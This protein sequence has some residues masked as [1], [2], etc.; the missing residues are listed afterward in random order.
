MA[1]TTTKHLPHLDG[2][3]GLAILFLLAGHFFPVRGINLGGLGVNFFF[4]LSGL[5]M[6]RILF[7][8]GVSIPTFYRRRI[9]RIFPLVYFFLSTI[10][11]WYL[12]RGMPVAWSEVLAAASFLN[13]YIR[14]GSSNSPMPFGHIWSLCV[15]EHAYVVLALVA[16]GVRAGWFRAQAAIGAALLGMIALGLAYSLSYHGPDLYHERWLRSEVSG[17]G[18]FVSVFLLLAFHGRGPRAVSWA[19]I[20]ALVAFGLVMHWWWFAPPARTFLGVTALAA[21]VNLLERAPG[22]VRALLSLRALRQ[23]GIWSFS[24]Y[25]WQQPFYMAVEAG[26]MHPAAGIGC[27]LLAGVVSFY[28]VEQPARSWLNRRWRESTTR[29]SA[30]QA[31]SIDSTLQ[32]ATAGQVQI[33]WN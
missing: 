15:E 8:E 12:I 16:L 21:A 26:G 28:L 4:V 3:R 31:C 24:I 32:V 6:G 14:N 30:P 13:N 9:A 22:W 11:L 1:K 10:V 33:R 20:A 25:V 19:V 2:W 29:S 27:A 7:L 17:F 5:L 18:I 23:L